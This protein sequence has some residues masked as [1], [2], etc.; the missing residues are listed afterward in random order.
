MYRYIPKIFARSKIDPEDHIQPRNIKTRLNRFDFTIFHPCKLRYYRQISYQ[1]Q[2][3]NEI[4]ISI[5]TWK[6]CSNAFT[7]PVMWQDGNMFLKTGQYKMSS[8]VMWLIA[9]IVLLC[10]ISMMRITVRDRDIN[11]LVL[12]SIFLLTTAGGIIL[13]TNLLLYKEIFVDLTNEVLH[14]NSEWGK[15]FVHFYTNYLI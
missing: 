11:R 1:I 4:K 13:R 2:S 12:Q 6:V 15:L 5:L 9:I 7:I 3:L 10:K 8:I 14:C